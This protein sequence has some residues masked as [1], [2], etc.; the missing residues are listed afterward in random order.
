MEKTI[1]KLKV[2]GYFEID[3]HEYI[4]IDQAQFQSDPISSL[5]GWEFNNYYSARAI[6]PDDEADYS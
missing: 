2:N 3:G 6:C 1:K 5:D 4:L